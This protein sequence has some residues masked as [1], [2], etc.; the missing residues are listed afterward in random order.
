MAISV[1]KKGKTVRLFFSTPE[2]FSGKNY[3][4][5]K[6]MTIQDNEDLLQM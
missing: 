6:E 3:L 1:T 5:Q 2:I 4:L